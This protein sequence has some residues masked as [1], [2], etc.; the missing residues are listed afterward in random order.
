MKESY[1]VGGKKCNLESI[2]VHLEINCEVS[3]ICDIE[4]QIGIL[5]QRSIIYLLTEMAEM[6]LKNADINKEN[7]MYDFKSVI[8]ILRK[9]LEAPECLDK[10]EEVILKKFHYYSIVLTSPLKR[11]LVVCG[12]YLKRATGFLFSGQD[13]WYYHQSADVE[14]GLLFGKLIVNHLKSSKHLFMV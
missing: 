12:C 4:T 8:I 7:D 11:N 3:E 9:W 14:Y 1:R 13:Y 5:N 10:K 6:A 2:H